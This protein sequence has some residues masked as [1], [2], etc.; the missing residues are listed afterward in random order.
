MGVPP[1]LDFSGRSTHEETGQASLIIYQPHGKKLVWSDHRL[2]LP[3]PINLSRVY[4]P[5][6]VLTWVNQ[7]HRS[8]LVLLSGDEFALKHLEYTRARDEKI[9]TI[10]ANMIGHHWDS[11]SL[12]SR[13]SKVRD[14][15]NIHGILHITKGYLSR[16]WQ[17]QSTASI[18][19]RGE[20]N[21]AIRSRNSGFLEHWVSIIDTVNIFG[22]SDILKFEFSY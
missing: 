1:R 18:V 13:V 12:N 8:V 5:R 20:N 19:K 22:Y 21:T 7:A 17:M 11:R 2:F 6:T 15:C 14:S 3:T 16:F 10:A 9:R 4:V